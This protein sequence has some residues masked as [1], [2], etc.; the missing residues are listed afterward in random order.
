MLRGQPV[1]LERS[2]TSGRALVTGSVDRAPGV[3]SGAV[4]PRAGRISPVRPPDQ[5]ATQQRKV[6]SCASGG[7]T[8]ARQLSSRG[9][10]AAPTVPRTRCVE[11]V[12]ARPTSRVIQC[13]APDSD[14]V[15]GGCPTGMIAGDR[16]DASRPCAQGCPG[17]GRLAGWDDDVHDGGD[18]RGHRAAAVL[19]G[20]SRVGG[21]HGP[22]VASWR[23]NGYGASVEGVIAQGRHASRQTDRERTGRHA[24]RNRVRQAG[25]GRD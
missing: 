2:I 10:S 12:R 9:A 15:T 24:H 11:T 5:S 22:A 1:L 3:N 8:T 13:A 7:S 17:H 18:V 25:R 21:E 4:P 14:A 6:D 20:H 23:R 19:Q 16:R